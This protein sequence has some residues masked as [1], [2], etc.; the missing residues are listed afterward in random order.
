MFASNITNKMDKAHF[1]P[2]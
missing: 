1:G 2:I